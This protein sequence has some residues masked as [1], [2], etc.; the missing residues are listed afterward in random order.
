VRVESRNRLRWTSLDWA[1]A[2][3]VAA[4]AIGARL[5]PGL[6]TIDDAYITYRYARNIVEGVGM[7]YNPGQPVL[8]TT[9]PLYTLLMAMLAAGL[10][11]SAYPAIS[12]AL[13]ALADGATAA[14]LYRLARRMLDHPLPG[15]LLGL[16]WAISPMSVTFAIGGMETSVSILLMVGAFSMYLDGRTVWAFGL[17]ALATLARPD[18]LIWVGPL[19]LA[20]VILLWLQ[21][22]DCPALARFPWVEV[23][24]YLGILAP[25]L[26]YA[27]A[28]YG[29]PIPRSI[30]AK[31]VAYH[32]GPTLALERLLQHYA[33]PFFE[34]ET[35]G[36]PSIR[37]GALVYPVLAALGGL[38]L[39]RSDVRSLPLVVYPWL[40]FA[41]FAAANPLIFR[42][43]LA[44][45]LPFYFLC[46]LAGVWG[47][48]TALGDKVER[49]KPLRTGL[50]LAVGA[51]WVGTSLNAWTLH[52][53]HG[54]D[55]PAPKMAW[56]KLELLYEQAGRE[57][58][59]EVGPETV[60]AAHDIGAVGY[61][62]RARL[63]DT[64][65]LVSPEATAYY[66]LDP[67][68]LATTGTAVPPDLIIAQQPDYIVILEAYGRNGLLKD[69][70]FRALYTLRETI[71][72]D[73]Y[74]SRGMLIYERIGP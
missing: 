35:F 25:W 44:P 42:W 8:G 33:T 63:L 24:V 50:M 40:Y 27:T 65:G 70:R 38:R 3:S 43:Y 14:L 19:G 53:D 21:R 66:P 68:L 37:V 69:P 18:A 26:I 5:L 28:T 45:P 6:R 56:H 32:L 17:A 52:P 47:L 46:I 1:L 4:L 41:V 13:N 59:D 61:Y 58:A 73:I 62:S 55:R 51:L 39:A 16:L 48:L 12:V 67:A 54:P 34:Q 31:Q 10:R 2:L 49:I 29:S 60:V 7:V 74:G 15:A 36:V 57:L 72:T 64:L 30:A 71:E 22:R 23:A 20:A 11:S 9:T